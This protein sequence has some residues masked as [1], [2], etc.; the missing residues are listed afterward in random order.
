MQH[1]KHACN[2]GC[3]IKFDHLLCRNSNVAQKSKFATTRCEA[4][5]SIRIALFMP[6][7]S[8]VLDRHK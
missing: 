1:I 2:H 3:K 5:F 6:W 7:I 4:S 8:D